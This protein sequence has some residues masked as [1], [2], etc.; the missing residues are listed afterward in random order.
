M[1]THSDTDLVNK[2]A[3]QLGI[4]NKKSQYCPNY[5]GRLEQFHVPCQL[6]N[7]NAISLSPNA[8]KL[9]FF[10]YF[11]GKGAYKQLQRYST[12]KS[13]QSITTVA[14]QKEISRKTGCSRN[15]LT[16]VTRELAGAG[17]IEP[18]SQRRVRRGELGTNKYFLLDP[19]TGQRLEE[20]PMKPYF[21]V[22]ACIVRNENMH[23]SLASMGRSEMALYATL[24][25]R[26]NRER[27]LS[28]E[29]NDVRL[30]KMSRLSRGMNGAFRKALESLQC[31]RLI[32]AGDDT[33]TLCNPL[34]GE[35]VV[36]APNANDDP[37]N[38]YDKVDGTHIVF[39]VDKPEA[40]LKWVTDSM[41]KG[42]DVVSASHD[43]YKIPCPFHKDTN[44]SLYFNPRK[45]TFYCFGCRA[46]GT[47]RD[48]IKQ[49][50]MI[51]E[52]E[53][54]RQQAHLLGIEAEFKAPESDAEAIYP[55][56]DRHAEPL[57]RVLRFPGKQFSQQRWTRHGWAYGVNGINKTLYRLPEIGCATIVIV[58]EGEKDADRINGLGLKG[59]AQS[60]RRTDDSRFPF[61]GLPYRDIRVV[62]TTSG[63]AESWQDGFAELLLPS[64][65]W[66]SGD[67]NIKKRYVVVMPDSDKAGQKYKDS[68]LKS[69]EKRAIPHCVVSFDGFKDVSDYLDAGNTGAELAKRISDELA[70]IGAEY[71]TYAQPVS[72]PSKQIPI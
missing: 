58:T 51:G 13:D 52:A 23:W 50:R 72:E 36:V 15:T 10:L 26:A 66:S 17:W 49:L 24:L 34:T 64:S 5:W 39:N 21:I 32:T 62:A 48:L 67:P 6:F 2:P 47:I 27:E 9:L 61:D 1:S 22:P 53:A 12:P 69:A 71:L 44:P 33:I 8:T 20:L 35:P 25:F 18:P 42:A 38:Y 43:E 56:T 59:Y 29:N 19:R 46:T 65:D 55:Y 40:L 45:N 14:S 60:A 3:T 4:F 68:I 41:P 57:Y 37:V 63:G 16:K 30:R 7:Q 31:K 70:R 28:F 54:I 11:K